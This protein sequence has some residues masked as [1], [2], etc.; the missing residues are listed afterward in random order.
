MQDVSEHKVQ[1]TSDVSKTEAAAAHQL[2]QQ[3][4]HTQEEVVTVSELAEPEK[5]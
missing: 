2:E 1:A 5:G 3:Q 4:W